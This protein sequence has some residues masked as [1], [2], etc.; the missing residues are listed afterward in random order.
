MD[1]SMNFCPWTSM[2]SAVKARGRR[3]FDK[4][5]FVHG[6]GR[7]GFDKRRF[8]HGR[9]RRGFSNAV[10]VHV[11][12]LRVFAVDADPEVGKSTESFIIGIIIII[13]DFSCDGR[14]QVSGGHLCLLIARPGTAT[15][16]GGVAP[17]SR[18]PHQPGSG[19]RVVTK[20]ENL[21]EKGKLNSNSRG[22]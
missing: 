9:G 10:V 22:R 15:R 1:L 8:V 11:H 19:W 3:G 13:I 5:R 21:F 7:R 12:G 2:V 16:W 4:R 18:I 20:R 6:R 14:S 17:I